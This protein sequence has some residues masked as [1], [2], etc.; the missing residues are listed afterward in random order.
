ME[1]FTVSFVVKD[2]DYLHLH[3]NLTNVVLYNII[4]IK[5][6]QLRE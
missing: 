5:I 6:A 3:S 4:S 1:I 2:L